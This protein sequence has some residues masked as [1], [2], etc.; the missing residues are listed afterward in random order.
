[1]KRR[2][3][4]AMLAL[5]AATDLRV[6]AAGDES[7]PAGPGHGEGRPDP[8]Q[9]RRLVARRAKAGMM[10]DGLGDTRGDT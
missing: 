8:S 3:L 2:D 4:L 5:G 9:E 1:M 6:R 10:R 7:G